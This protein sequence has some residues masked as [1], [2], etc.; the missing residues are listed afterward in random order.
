MEKEQS[1]AIKEGMENGRLGRG[2]FQKNPNKQK[3]S[4]ATAGLQYL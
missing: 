3:L 2:G 1:K 4:L